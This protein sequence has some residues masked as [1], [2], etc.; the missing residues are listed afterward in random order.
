MVVVVLCSVVCVYIYMVCMR[1]GR[2]GMMCVCVC[3]LYVVVHV[4]MCVVSCFHSHAQH[5]LQVS[6]NS[7]DLK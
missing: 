5:K 1:V 7:M 6:N 3:A 4:Y 2:C